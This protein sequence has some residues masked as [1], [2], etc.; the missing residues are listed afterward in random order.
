MSPHEVRMAIALSNLEVR[1]EVERLER[2]EMPMFDAILKSR[3]RYSLKEL[4]R[5]AKP[6]T[7]QELS[8]ETQWIFDHGTIGREL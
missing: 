8:E 7:I 6:K 2:E 3:K 4:L 5:N 1:A